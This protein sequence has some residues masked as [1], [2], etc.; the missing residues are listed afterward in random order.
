MESKF[1]S[2]PS[3]KFHAQVAGAG[4][5]STGSGRGVVLLIHGY[6]PAFNSWRTWQKNIAAL[7]ERHRV[8]ALDLL[9][10]GE[11]DKPEPHPDAAFEARALI[12][13]MDAEKIARAVLVGL[14]WGGGIAQR[15]AATVPERVVKL[16]L[17]DS[18]SDPASLGKLD[19]Q[20]MPTLITWDEEDAVI[21]VENAHT[22]ARAVPHARL[23]IFTRAE[24]DPDANPDNRHWSQETHARA[25]NRAV[26]EFLKE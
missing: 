7:A 2:T 6:S 11:S 24:R 10:Y 9:G 1:I 18:T 15:I 4:E 17:V 5:P 14:S 22:L 13:L 25:W 16:V 21:P 26:T 20:K 23:R 3:G 19:K 12:E 8:Y